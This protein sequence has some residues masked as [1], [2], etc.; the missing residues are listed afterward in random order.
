MSK[1]A[2]ASLQV[3][4]ACY[5][6]ATDFATQ[7]QAGIT[8][9]KLS[10]PAIPGSALLRASFGV[11]LEAVARIARSRVETSVRLIKPTEATYED[12]ARLAR[13]VQMVTAANAASSSNASSLEELI[14]E[15]D[16]QSTSQRMADERRLD[17][18]CALRRWAPEL[19][20]EAATRAFRM[21]R[22]RPELVVGADQAGD[23]YVVQAASLEVMSLAL[24][25]TVSA[26]RTWTVSL[27]DAGLWDMIACLT[28]CRTLTTPDAM[29]SRRP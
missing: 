14:A 18:E 28:V 22:L 26:D 8:I 11:E 17:H 3:A 24:T 13:A 20:I 6:R 9:I 27:M 21:R 10:A 19:Y 1:L 7:R 2:P 15:S 23:I 29:V 16:S 4:A 5:C 12:A 25:E